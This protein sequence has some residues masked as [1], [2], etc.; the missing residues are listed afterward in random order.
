VQKRGARSVWAAHWM[1]CIGRVKVQYCWQLHTFF[2]AACATES[3]TA[4][5]P[6]DA[7]EEVMEKERVA[8]KCG[9][10]A[11][12]CIIQRYTSS[13]L[14]ISARTRS[15]R[16]PCCERRAT[17]CESTRRAAAKVSRAR[18]PPR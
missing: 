17:A 18:Q 14:S 5:V 3:A 9:C 4:E 13:R 12:Q 15:L 2:P 11:S 8:W 10:C 6:N 16:L 1:L 7:R